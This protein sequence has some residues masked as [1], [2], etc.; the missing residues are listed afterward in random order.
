MNAWFT[1]LAN[2]F[3]T[4][5]AKNNAKKSISDIEYKLQQVSEMKHELHKEVF[6]LQELVQ[7]LERKCQRYLEDKRELRST[8]SELQ[9]KLNEASGNG[10]KLQRHLD[11]LRQQHKTEAEE[12]KQF[13]SDLLMTVRVANDFKT[14]AQQ[15]VEKLQALTRQLQDRI[16]GLEAENERLKVI[17]A[18]GNFYIV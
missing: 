15:D 6:D 5:V 2:T 7:E 10:E 9:G 1:M 16:V 12:W 3:F 4:K 11:E 13:Q 14:E 8:V 17:F 18:F